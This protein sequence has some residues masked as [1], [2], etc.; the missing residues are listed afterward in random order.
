MFFDW[1][2]HML[3]RSR[4]ALIVTSAILAGVGVIRGAGAA[5]VAQTISP[6]TIDGWTISWPT[7]GIGLAVTQ[8][9][10]SSA[11]VDVEKSATFTAP[12]QGLQISFVPTGTPTADTFVIPDET[13]NNQ[14]G[15]PF[16]G[17]SFI[18]IN[19]GSV[20]ATFAGGSPGFIPPTGPGYDYTTVSLVNGKTEL[21][22]TGTQGNG[23][24]SFWGDGNPGSSGDNLVIDAPA[25]SVFALKELA[26]SGGGNVVP[27]PAAAW[28]SLIGLAGLGIFAT[29]RGK[30]RRTA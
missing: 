25:G 24:T 14:T 11:Q 23:V 29:V 16:K 20:N 7:P 5:P 2:V 21:D 10:S 30:L 15:Q 19:T 9:G 1:E 18:L 27:L 12:N 17:F 8:D 13:I 6:A 3:G 28:Q 4:K 22:Y 26:V